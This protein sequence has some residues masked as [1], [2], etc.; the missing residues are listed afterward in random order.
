L[1]G[2]FKGKGVPSGRGLILGGNYMARKKH[3]AAISDMV[4][5]KVDS[6]AV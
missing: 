2:G 6:Q 4:A 3:P 5:A 1:A